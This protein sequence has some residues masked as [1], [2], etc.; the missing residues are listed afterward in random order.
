MAAYG[1]S[2]GRGRPTASLRCTRHGDPEAVSLE[3][4]SR[5]AR[6]ATL[7]LRT[8]GFYAL[9]R[10]RSGGGARLRP[11][12][13]LPA[14]RAGR[15][16]ADPA[17]AGGRGGGPAGASSAGCG[18]WS[19]WASGAWCRAR[20]ARRRCRWRWDGTVR[21]GRRALRRERGAPQR[22]AATRAGAAA[23]ERVPGRDEERGRAR[24]RRCAST[25]GAGSWCWRSGCGCGCCSRGAS[26]ARAG[27][28]AWAA[29]RDAAASPS[30][31]ELLARLYTTSRGLHAVALRAAVPGPRARLRGVRAASR[32]AGRAGGL[33]PRARGRQL[34]PGQR[35][36][37]PCRPRGGLDRLLGRGGLRAGALAR[38]RRDAARLGG[39]RRGR[40]RDGVAR[41]ARRFETNRFYQP[42]LLEAPDPWL[43]EALASGATRAKSFSLAGVDRGSSADGRARRLP[44]GGVRVGPAGRPPRERVARTATLVGEAQFAGKQ[45]Y[46]MSLSVPASLLREGANELSLTNVAD[47]GVSSL[48]FLD[49][50]T[51][52]HPQASS[53]AGGRFEG[54]WAESGTV[55]G[56]GRRRRAGG[57]RRR[58]ARR[59]RGERH[60]GSPA[61]QAAGG[62]LRFQAEAGH[63]YLAVSQEALLAPARR[64]AASRRR[65]AR[66]ANQA[67]YLLIAPRAFL[68]AAEPLRA[69]PAA[70]RAS[71][72]APSRSRRSRTSSGTAS[73]RPRRSRASSPTPSSP[74][75]G[76]RR[77]TCCCWATRATTRAT[78]SA[79]RSPRRCRR[80]G[81][82]RATCG[83]SP[84]RCS[85]R[86]TA[87]TRCRTSRSDGCRRR[88]VEQAEALV[89]KLLAWEDSGQ[90]LAGA[91]ALV[92]D[93]P[94]LAG[95]FEADVRDIAAELP[96]GPR[97][98][99]CC[100]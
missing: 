3:V 21:A 60:A 85:P 2:V 86:S 58:R 38:R 41:L 78:S 16:A 47:T 40:G 63:R 20:S 98:R 48:V 35:A 24:S 56:L 67:D 1:S 87:R 69:A 44:A 93:N 33:P 81:R 30:P 77:A 7:E 42:G 11:R 36:L 39:A 43:W 8:G 25:R 46:R 37:L 80:C 57:A 79:P 88:R 49:R 53:L 95:D 65:C 90:G 96:R 12:L 23:A 100:C 62:S 66:R 73:R 54:T 18:R 82:R 74:G 64:G 61:T 59:R 26:R 92:A 22:S 45:P 51:L 31:G 29:R 83:P 55:D 34:R 27:G 76:P 17:R 14:G 71:R 68:A 84:T 13:R 9:H 6:Q 97:A 50:F 4:L 32:A 52:A 19:W 28:A 10:G 70:T 99:S 72:R 91:A 89:A 15:G 94:D 5:D 75:R